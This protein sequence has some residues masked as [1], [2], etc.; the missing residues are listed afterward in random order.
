[1]NEY[2]NL[3]Q[4]DFSAFDADFAKS[5]NSTR[6]NALPSSSSGNNNPSWPIP[7]IPLQ[8]Q[9][10]S[11]PNVNVN[12]GANKAKTQMIQEWA[13]SQLLAQQ[14]RMT[15]QRTQ[16]SMSHK[17]QHMSQQRMIQSAPGAAVGYSTSNASMPLSMPKSL[18]MPMGISEAMQMQMSMTKS[19]SMGMSMGKYM[20][21]NSGMIGKDSN[22][23]SIFGKNFE[24]LPDFDDL[25]DFDLPTMNNVSAAAPRAP[26]APFQPSTFDPSADSIQPTL[27]HPLPDEEISSGVTPSGLPIYTINKEPITKLAGT[28]RVRREKS[29]TIK[30]PKVAKV[31]AE[32]SPLEIN[33]VKVLQLPTSLLQRKQ[34]TKKSSS[35][36]ATVPASDVAE[37]DAAEKLRAAEETPPLSNKEKKV[38][39]WEPNREHQELWCG[40]EH[41][42]DLALQDAL[43]RYVPM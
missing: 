16:Q 7:S 34:S 23:D 19:M 40:L 1:M 6:G 11:I 15:I 37:D 12:N 3:D 5:L 2:T 38:R 43:S 9:V 14:Q 18:S 26:S 30:N 27:D 13:N 4:F 41:L 32:A 33:P 28:K 29:P 35:T 17:Q 20:P 21:T 36:Q 8:P 10:S 31:R 22:H 25:T 39:K 24:D 42:D